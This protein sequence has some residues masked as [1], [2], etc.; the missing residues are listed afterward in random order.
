MTKETITSL[1]RLTG[2]NV[3]VIMI[4]NILVIPHHIVTTM[5]IP[6]VAIAALGT[7]MKT[8]T[9][10]THHRGMPIAIGNMKTTKGQPPHTTR[11]NRAHA[12]GDPD[13]V[14]LWILIDMFRDLVRLPEGTRIRMPRIVVTGE[15]EREV[16]A[17]AGPGAGAEV[18]TGIVLEE[19]GIGVEVELLTHG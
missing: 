12:G 5:M 18:D 11:P 9:T 3:I 8:M 17:E 1:H 10:T 15:A 16:E 7:S 4:M 19:E 13:R 6:S 14:I 2:T